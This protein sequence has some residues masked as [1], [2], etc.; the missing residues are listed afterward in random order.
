MLFMEQLVS[1]HS[2]SGT[3]PSYSSGANSSE[4][5][6]DAELTELE[7]EQGAGSTSPITTAQRGVM[8]TVA[9]QK[10]YPLT[11]GLMVHGLADG[12]ALGVSALSSSE[13]SP[14]SNVSFIVFLALIIHKG[15]HVNVIKY[16]CSVLLKSN[17]LQHL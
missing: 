11:F 17:Q 12:L 6:F 16:H 5:H 7:R 14:L 2:H 10:S 9:S 13:S 1:S 15:K 3:L 4:V 8:D